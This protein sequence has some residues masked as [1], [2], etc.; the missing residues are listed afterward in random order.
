MPSLRLKRNRSKESS[1]PRDSPNA[2]KIKI[3]SQSLAEEIGIS[4]AEMKAAGVLAVCR[5]ALVK[6][7]AASRAALAKHRSSIDP[8]LTKALET[9]GGYELKVNSI[10][11]HMFLNDI[12][13]SICVSLHADNYY[14]FTALSD[15][16]SQSCGER[17]RR[18]G[19]KACN[20]WC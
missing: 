4:R 20:C 8:D 16:A 14:V 7:P 6:G 17:G 19:A 18:D 2:E 5:A 11:F 10:S 1:R 15:P 9:V 3:G 13:Y 12:A